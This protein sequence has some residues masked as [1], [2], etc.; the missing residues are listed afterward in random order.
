MLSLPRRA[1]RRDQW[2]CRP[3]PIWYVRCAHPARLGARL[4]SDS[5]CLATH[6]C[7]TCHPRL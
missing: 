4:V 5:A 3:T 2:A 6:S 1:G 7:Q